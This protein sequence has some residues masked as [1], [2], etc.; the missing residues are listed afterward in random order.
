MLIDDPA[1]DMAAALGADATLSVNREDGPPYLFH[2]IL[3]SLETVDDVGSAFLYR[4]VLVPR[5]WRSTLGHHNRVF[6]DES[7]PAI[8]QTVLRDAGMAVDDA[9]FRADRELRAPAA[10]LPVPGEPLRLPL[11]ADRARGH[12]LLLRAGGERERLFVTDDR[13]FHQPLSS[14]PVRYTRVSG[15]GAAGVNGLRSF[16]CEQSAIVGSV[17]VRARPASTRRR[18][19]TPPIP[20]PPWL[21]SRP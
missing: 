18:T 1:F 9:T 5:L 7:A 12:L 6:V 13:S 8:L 3:A 14:D 21:P 20:T 17:E 15:A 10:R 16:T 2:G 19:R 11:A 4:A